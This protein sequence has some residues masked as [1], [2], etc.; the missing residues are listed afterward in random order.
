MSTIAKASSAEYSTP[1][2]AKILGI[3]DK[4]VRSWVEKYGLPCY[5]QPNGR[6]RFKAADVLAYLRSKKMPIPAELT[7]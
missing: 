3:T 4:T 5:H 1:E 6:A 7:K 2:I